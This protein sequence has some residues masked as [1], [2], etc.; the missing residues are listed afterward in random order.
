MQN[1]SQEISNGPWSMQKSSSSAS[2]STANQ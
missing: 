2:L 1:A